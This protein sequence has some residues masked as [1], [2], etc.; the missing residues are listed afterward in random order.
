MVRDYSSQNTYSWIT[1]AGDV[2]QHA[3]QA[4]VRSIGS[5]SAFESQMATGVFDIR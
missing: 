4:R 3:V 5:S 2:G 1:T